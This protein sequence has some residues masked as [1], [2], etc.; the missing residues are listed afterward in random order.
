MYIDIS[1]S[2]YNVLCNVILMFNILVYFNVMLIENL[3]T[4]D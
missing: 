2:K 3:S 4:R 1:Y